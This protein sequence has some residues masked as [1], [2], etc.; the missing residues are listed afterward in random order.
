[1][2]GVKGASGNDGEDGSDSQ[3]WHHG[4]GDP[5]TLAEY[6]DRDY[7]LDIDTGNV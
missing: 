1:M 6:G 5:V 2:A 7:Y 3:D 4:N